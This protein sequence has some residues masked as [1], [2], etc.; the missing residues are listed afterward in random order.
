MFKE[1]SKIILNHKKHT[2]FYIYDQD[3][4][5]KQIKKIRSAFSD[6]QNFE[7]LYAIKAN[8]SDI[9]LEE[10]KKAKI[11]IAVSSLGELKKVRKNKIKIISY[12]APF[13]PKE[14]VQMARKNKVEIN[15]NNYSE[16]VDSHLD[17]VGARINPEVG[18]SYFKDYQAGSRSSQFGIP[19]KEALKMNLSQVSRLHMHT[20][21]DSYQ[22]DVFIEGLKRLLLVAEKF[23]RITTINLGGG[24]AVPIGKNGKEFDV[25]LYARKIIALIREFNK[26]NGRNLKIQIEPGNYIVRPAGYYISKVMAVEKKNGKIFYFID[27][28]KHH[29]KG[30]ANVEKID[31]VTRASKETKASII[32]CTCQRSDVFID[33]AK[34][35][36]LNIGDLVIVSMAGAYCLVQSDN[37]HLLD[38]PKEFGFVEP[39]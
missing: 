34:I 21:S 23:P 7:L 4:I 12:T 31:F 11:G 16:L 18:W 14:V 10:I 25:R 39:F 29:L 37:F 38:K 8:Y 15:F 24:M 19:Y 35:P 36:I 28:T 32:G 1:L 26:R 30:L 2:P 33:Y 5:S 20:S 22:I 3:V 13:I 9:V 17:N 6:Y 27:G